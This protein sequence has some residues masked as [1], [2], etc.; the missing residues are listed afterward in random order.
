MAV[1]CER[2]FLTA[3]DGSCKTPIAGHCTINGDKMHF[4]VRCFSPARC[5]VRMRLS[6][7]YIAALPALLDGIESVQRHEE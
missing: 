7:H 3:L 6:Q 2:S 1:V 5:V 4:E